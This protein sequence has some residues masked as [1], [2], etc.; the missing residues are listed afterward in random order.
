M[1]DLFL[2]T[3][4]DGV[5]QDDYVII[6]RELLSKFQRLGTPDKSVAYAKF[7]CERNSTSA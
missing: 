7:L 2:S 3:T 4:L 5:V 6:Y 1:Q